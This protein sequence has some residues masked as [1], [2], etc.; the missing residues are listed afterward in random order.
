MKVDKYPVPLPGPKSTTKVALLRGLAKDQSIFIPDT[1]LTKSTRKGI[2]TL[3]KL[4]KIEITTRKV[5][6]GL[7]IWRTDGASLP[8]GPVVEMVSKDEFLK[9]HPEYD[10]DVDLETGEVP[11]TALEKVQAA[12]DAIEMD[13]ESTLFEPSL[14]EPEDWR[15]TKDKPQYDDS[16]KIFRKQF[17][18][19]D[20]KR[21]R[22]VEVDEFNHEDV[23]KIV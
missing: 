11:M 3:A 15:F 20:G 23:I 21:T 18:F 17:L 9:N 8:T 2:Y 12:I 19:P 7:R 22:T 4:A 14:S 16:G 10:D 13:A 5:E 1:E 6:G